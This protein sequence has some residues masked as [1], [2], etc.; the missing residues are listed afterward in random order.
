M[1]NTSVIACAMSCWCIAVQFHE[2]ISPEERFSLCY[3]EIARQIFDSKKAVSC[4]RQA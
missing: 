1:H 2:W 4:I 3:D